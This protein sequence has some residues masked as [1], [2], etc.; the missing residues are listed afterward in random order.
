MSHLLTRLVF[1]FAFAA[2]PTSALC[3]C[4]HIET[5]G[6]P[7]CSSSQYNPFS[8]SPTCFDCPE[9]H[10]PSSSQ[11]SCVPLPDLQLVGASLDDPTSISCVTTRQKV[12]PFQVP[13]CTP[14]FPTATLTISSSDYLSS[15]GNDGT[16]LVNG[17]RVFTWRWAPEDSERMDQYAPW[18]G[19]T[20]QSTFC[21]TYNSRSIMLLEFYPFDVTYTQ[22]WLFNRSSSP[23]PSL[24]NAS[25]PFLAPTR[26]GCFDTA[27]YSA[28]RVPLA[29]RIK[30]I[31]SKTLLILFV[32][33][34]AVFTP[35]D[36]PRLRATVTRTS[37]SSYILLSI[38]DEV[39]YYENTNPSTDR[40]ALDI[41]C[42]F[43][44]T[45]HEIMD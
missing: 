45:E 41:G 1:F 43:G 18:T 39:P 12:S 40:V 5:S 16:V 24:L 27:Y 42:N 32:S 17:V 36:H 26:V 15:I 29:E 2:F 28:H 35:T 38:V 14:Q 20:F 3:G 34:S 13:M 44:L 6:C 25:I 9:N 8:A 11:C 23:F 37:L 22:E 4:G 10:V 21:P 19:R 31:P 7:A 30:S 33:D